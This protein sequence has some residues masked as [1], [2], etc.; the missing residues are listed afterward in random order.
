MRVGKTVPHP[1]HK[2][3]FDKTLV[4]NATKPNHPYDYGEKPAA[5]E[6]LA[7]KNATGGQMHIRPARNPAA[8]KRKAQ[9]RITKVMQEAQRLATAPEQ[10]EGE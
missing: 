5:I 8:A 7:S 1:P 9:R 10:S 6:D 3:L 4:A 2:A